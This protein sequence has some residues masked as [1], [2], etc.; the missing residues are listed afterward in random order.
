MKKINSNL[1][2]LTEEE[3][4]LLNINKNMAK[5]QCLMPFGGINYFE[6]DEANQRYVYAKKDETIY[7]F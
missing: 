6:S 2:V 7:Q 5:T 4:F 3:F 1:M